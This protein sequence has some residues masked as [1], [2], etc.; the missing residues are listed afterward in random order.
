MSGV[1]SAPIA[2]G[3]ATVDADIV[4][5][6]ALMGL[7]G[8][9]E[10][11][12]VVP[13][14]GKASRLRVASTS[15]DY[16]FVAR[17]AQGAAIARVPATLQYNTG[18]HT[19]VREA[20][21]VLSALV[22]IREAVS[23]GIDFKGTS[24]GERRRSKSPPDVRVFSVG[25]GL[26]ISRAEAMDVEWTAKDRDGDPLEVRIEF[27]AEPNM[28]FRPIYIGPNRGVWR[29]PGRILSETRH[30]RLRV[31]V[32]DGF[33][34]S[35]QIVE[36]IIVNASPPIIEVLSRA[37]G[38]SFPETTPIRLLASAFGDGDTPL[39]GDAIQWLVDGQASGKGVEAEFRDLKPGKHV[40]KVV[41]RDG[42]LSSERE[43]TF[44]VSR[45]AEQNLGSK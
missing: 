28:P 34:E 15:D 35:Q 43:L 13:L 11:L 2:S 36:P 7:D 27:A 17:D 8:R 10:F 3:D 26:P 39:T 4:E 23:I 30:G 38:S 16:S 33:N 22:P 31:V 42:T 14:H 12:S 5:A 19:D 21:V 29:V 24:I 1:G 41:V 45:I 44:V 25:K 18:H 32:N 40:A 37:N 20:R 6:T 9:A